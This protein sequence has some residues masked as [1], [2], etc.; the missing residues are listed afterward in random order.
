MISN[1]Y[2]VFISDQTIE[3]IEEK[4]NCSISFKK[5][6][7][8]WHYSLI[9][10]G[11]NSEV[12][13]DIVKK[14]DNQ[15]VKIIELHKKIKDQSTLTNDFDEAQIMKFLNKFCHL[16]YRQ[17]LF[18]SKIEIF[19]NDCYPVIKNIL[20]ENTNKKV[21]LVSKIAEFFKNKLEGGFSRYFQENLSN[22]DQDCFSI[23]KEINKDLFFN[24]NQ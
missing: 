12:V 15:F 2:N 17:F 10:K 19:Q 22:F 8:K 11:N 13:G 24:Q 14:S 20:E 7:W 6:S 23:V 4:I 21:M 9:Q 1:N 18:Q 3:L 16:K 5:T